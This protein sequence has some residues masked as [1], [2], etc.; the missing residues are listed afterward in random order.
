[1]LCWS[2]I[3]DRNWWNHSDYE[4]DETRQKLIESLGFT[5]IRINPDPDPDVNFD[6]NVKITKMY[7]CINESSITLAVNLA[8]K[9]F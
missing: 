3:G 4:N 2:Q 5:F 7:N 9:S 1:M 8:E 6:L